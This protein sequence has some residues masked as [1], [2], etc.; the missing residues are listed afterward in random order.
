MNKTRQRREGRKGRKGRLPLLRILPF[1]PF[2]SF[3]PSCSEGTR[4][5]TIPGQSFVA[6]LVYLDRDGNREPG[7]PDEALQGVGVRLL[8]AGTL[9]TLSRATS[10]ANGE[11]VF[12]AV[13]VGRYTIVVPGAP[14]FGDS[15][16]VVRIDTAD[17][18][19][20][21]DDTSFVNVSVS[22]PSYTLADARTRPL[23]EKIFVEGLA[24]NNAS[25]FGDS[26]V[27]LR[28]TTGAI[29]ITGARGPLVAGG[30][31]AR[32]L[33]KVAALNGQPVIESGQATLI[34]IVGLPVA[35][36]VTTAEAA[37]AN[38]GALDA[39]LIRIVDGTI[40]NDTTTVNGNYQFTVDD[41][42]G[43]V[44]VVLD[45]DASL[46]RTPYVPG[47]VIDAV[48]VLVPDGAGGWLLK[49]R[50]NADLVVK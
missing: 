22:F 49:P 16:Q 45:Q 42:S 38:G 8:V 10:D 37:S 5:V 9:D 33:G 17:V 31:S 28:D 32:F 29:R 15:L 48:G 50:N 27:H 39:E 2:L 12:G 19:L 34:Q 30:D 18:S 23:G 13:P 26:T 36:R 3:L 14:I 41:G 35:V 20:G 7:G 24:L 1:L 25:T 21:M 47:V 46:T 4:L 43:P 40:A 11:F 6:G 44:L